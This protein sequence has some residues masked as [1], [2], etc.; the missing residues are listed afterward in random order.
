MW[1]VKRR[2]RESGSVVGDPWSV[3]RKD[4]ESFADGPA[5]ALTRRIPDP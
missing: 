5:A 1:D 4:I 3:V 2:T